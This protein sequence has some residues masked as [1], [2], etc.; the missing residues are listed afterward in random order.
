MAAINIDA[1]LE[2]F[3]NETD[4]YLE[5]GQA[6][7]ESGVVDS[8]GIE[9]AFAAGDAQKALYHAHKIKG[10]ALTVG[11]D[12]LASFA[13]KLE[14]GLRSDPAADYS[15]LASSISRETAIVLAEMT[16]IIR[17]LKTRS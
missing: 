1:A 4:I 13:G 5:I 11:A 3:D 2:R 8:K 14:A 6:F 15:V 12:T 16:E 10:A 17:R 7:L 9:E